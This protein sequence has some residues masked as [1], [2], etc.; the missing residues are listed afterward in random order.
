M[1]KFSVTLVQLV[2][3]SLLQLVFFKDV[4]LFNRAL[5]FVY[6]AP[7]LLLP[8]DTKP[9]PAMLIAF[10]VGFTIDIFYAT[11][12]MHTA[13]CVM[14]MFLRPYVLNLITPRGGYDLSVQPFFHIMGARWF[15]IYSCLMIAIHHFTLFLVE[16]FTFSHIVQTLL[17]T[18]FSTLFTLSVILILQIL[19]HKN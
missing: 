14:M 7:L 2:V 10:F 4:T 13:A 3:Y 15:L 17:T 19:F 12:G 16:A 6:A 9:V 5:C 1:S 18:L 8:L 11:G